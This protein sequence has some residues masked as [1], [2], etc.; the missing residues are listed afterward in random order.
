MATSCGANLVPVS[1]VATERSPLVAPKAF[2]VDVCGENY[3]RRLKLI[4][5]AR[6]IVIGLQGSLKCCVYW[7]VMCF[8]IRICNFHVVLY[9]TPALIVK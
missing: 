7:H 3:S 4:R 5:A 8:C 2:P 9:Y 1:C 6:A